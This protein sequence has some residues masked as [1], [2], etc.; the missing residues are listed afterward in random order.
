MPAVECD[1]IEK[2]K[3]RY[4]K[5]GSCKHNKFFMPRLCDNF[6]EVKQ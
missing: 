2:C 1:R 5:C 4:K 3:N 6:E